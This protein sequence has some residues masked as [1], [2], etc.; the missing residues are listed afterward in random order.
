[1]KTLFARAAGFGLVV[2]CAIGAT[3]QE[4]APGGGPWQHDL[5]LYTARGT[6]PFDSGRVLVERGGVPSLLS[7]QFDRLVATF[8]WFPFDRRDAFDRVA[9]M[10]SYDNGNTWGKPQPIEVAGLP[11]GTMRP[12]DPTLVQLDDG[13]YRLYFTSS[14]PEARNPATYSAVSHDAIHFT[15]EPGR[16]FGVDG[17]MVLDCAVARLGELWHYFAPVPNQPGRGFHAVSNDGL[18]FARRTDVR[19]PGDRQW[20]GC[21]VAVAEG[22]RFFGSGRGGAWSAVSTDGDTWRL[23]SI[24]YPAGADPGVAITRDDRLVMIATG[25]PRTDA[26]RVRPP[27]PPVAIEQ[28]PPEPPR[29]SERRT[30]GV[31]RPAGPV[32]LSTFP[33]RIE[34]IASICPMG[35]MVGGHVTPSDHIGIAP[36]DML[37]PADHYDVLAPADGY[38]VE[39]QRAPKGNPDPAVP[40]KFREME[41]YKVVIEHSGTFWTYTSLINVLDERILDALGGAPAAGPPVFLR[42]PV[43]GGQVIGKMGGGHGIDFGVINTEVTLKGFVVPE[44]F[45]SRDPHKRHT[46]DPFDY[47]DEPLR[48]RLLALNPRKTEPLGGKIDY[49][50]DGRLVGNWYKVGSGGYAAPRGKLDYWVGHLA[51]VYHHIDASQIT[52]SI[53]DFGGAVRQFWVKGNAPNPAT[54]SA[55]TGPVKYEL[56][57][58]RI[59][60]AGQ[61]YEGIPTGVQGVLLVELARDRTLRVEAFPGKTAEQV[62][63]FSEAAILYER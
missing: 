24:A 15:F 49:D 21:A 46:V 34:D 2:V 48:S 31:D 9:V 36:K 38:V 61:T 42:M 5:Y 58:P 30:V 52:V 32:R 11:R 63:G 13:R 19:V 40:Q 25:L 35:L 45:R 41:M 56:V 62:R 29:T 1:M 23:E 37:A 57:F 51:I 18:N 55:E 8:Q 59:G 60:S 22:L 39:V 14:G 7:D 44:R 20:L 43:T 3:G 47:V 54:V 28:A 53:G 50:V 12:C 6:T 4:A 33:L 27:F 26:G 10:F 17:E 16:R